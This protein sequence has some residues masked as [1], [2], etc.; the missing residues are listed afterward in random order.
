MQIKTRRC[1][2]T[3]IMAATQKQDTHMG[4]CV[5]SKGTSEQWWQGCKLLFFLQSNI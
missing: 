3:L 1:H 4:E 5:E 2:T